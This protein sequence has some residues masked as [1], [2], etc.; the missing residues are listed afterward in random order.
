MHAVCA[1]C[2]VCERVHGVRVCVLVVLELMVLCVFMCLSLYIY[3]YIYMWIF[4]K[5]YLHR[6]VN[7]Y[8]CV[9]MECILLFLVRGVMRLVNSVDERYLGLLIESSVIR[10]V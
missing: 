9:C 7:L 3:I 2:C 4:E 5:R 8:V 1:V 10:H 6:W